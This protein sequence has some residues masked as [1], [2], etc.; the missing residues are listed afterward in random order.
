MAPSIDRSVVSGF[1]IFRGVPPEDID[2]VLALAR[3]RRLTEGTAAFQQGE[4]A[5]EF[6]LLLHGRL[7]VQQTTPDGQQVVV[8]YINPGDLFGIAHAVRRPDYPGTAIA[9]VEST[10][11]VWPES[12]WNAF[13]GRN[14]AFATGAMQTVGARLQEANARI[15]ELSTEAVERRIAHA[16]LRLANQAGRK[17]TGGIEI[18]FPVSRADIAEMSGTTLHTVSRVMSGW[19]QQGLVTLGRRRVTVN[20]PHRLFILAEGGPLRESGRGSSEPPA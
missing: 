17:V 19:Q 16:I 18:D 9:T 11:L 4:P 10:A 12:Q 5:S 13:V 2:A 1:E 7:K 8:R 3:P 6:F 14:P 15:R 20:D